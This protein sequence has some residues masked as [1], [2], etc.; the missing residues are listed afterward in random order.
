[1]PLGCSRV[2]SLYINDVRSNTA[3]VNL[4]HPSH[5]GIVIG[6]LGYHCSQMQSTS[7]ELV[8]SKLVKHKNCLRCL[9]E[10]TC[11]IALPIL[12][13]QSGAHKLEYLN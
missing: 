10:N 1:M 5:F 11:S 6:V 8:F 13:E 3:E 12:I 7:P 9:L 4:G 2:A